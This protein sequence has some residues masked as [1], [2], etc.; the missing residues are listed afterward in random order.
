MK[1]SAPLRRGAELAVTMMGSKEISDAS[2]PA[3]PNELE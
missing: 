2:I 1:C 3:M